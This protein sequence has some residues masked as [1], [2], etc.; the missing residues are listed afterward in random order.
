VVSCFVRIITVVA[1][2]GAIGLQWIALQSVAWTTM[3]ISY[4]KHA[5]L[6]EAISQTF[7]GAH[8]CSLCHAVN[9]GKASEKKSSSNSNT[10]KIDI[11]SANEAGKL[12]R[13]IIPITYAS[14]I[15]DLIKLRHSPPFP[16]PRSLA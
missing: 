8:P 12:L 9:K 1:L 15:R 10:A 3:L 16:P 5:P 7:N 14:G 13:P 4:S 11:I 6:R 2:C